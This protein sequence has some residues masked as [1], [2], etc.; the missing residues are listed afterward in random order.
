MF[1]LENP[2]VL[3]GRESQ[4]PRPSVASPGLHWAPS[5]TGRDA[6]V[7]TQRPFDSSIF[8]AYVGQGVSQLMASGSHTPT[9]G[10]LAALVAMLPWGSSFIPGAQGLGS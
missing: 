4:A 9:Q 1:Y 5:P 7:G 6:T 8:R 3:V 2:T 10:A